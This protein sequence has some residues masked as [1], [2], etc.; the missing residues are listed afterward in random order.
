MISLLGVGEFEGD[1]SDGGIVE[2]WQRVA[3]F[4]LILVLDE[5][6]VLGCQPH[7]TKLSQVLP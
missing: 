1:W 6:K 3:G 7:V 4:E 5:S 2:G